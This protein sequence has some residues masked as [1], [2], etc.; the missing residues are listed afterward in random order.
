MSIK[1]SDYSQYNAYKNCC[2]PAGTSVGDNVGPQGPS[3]PNLPS[4]S[5]F[6]LIS[7]GFGAPVITTDAWPCI[8][9]TAPCSCTTPS[10][11]YLLTFAK[12]PSSPLFESVF[13]IDGKQ[14]LLLWDN[15]N[16]KYS[17]LTVSDLS[18]S[19]LTPFN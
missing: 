19:L 14:Y 16:K 18:S 5:P 2:T 7:G 10:G 3:G 12:T 4:P 13:P 8:Q 6:T 15:I 1:Y 9:G 17:Y 11:E